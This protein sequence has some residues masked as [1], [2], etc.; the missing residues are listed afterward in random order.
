MNR[1][2]LVV[3]DIPNIRE[4]LEITLRFK[5]YEVVSAADGEEALEIIK[6][7]LPSLV[8]TDILMPRM[9]GFTFIHTLRQDPRTRP[10]PV[11][12]LSATYTTPEDKHF[13]MSL[14]AVRFLEKPIDTEE[15]LLTVAE[16][17]TGET[18]TMP[19]PMD[20]FKFYLE[21]RSRLENKLGHKN[22][23]ITRMERLVQ[24]LPESQKAAFQSLLADAIR[25]RD[26]IQ[27]QLDDIYRR[28]RKND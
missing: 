8:I 17:L 13:A 16:T 23:Q 4:M 7:S 15:F 12:V 10:L 20:D 6:T 3:E 5:G 9:D 21:Y 25:D 24:V 22:S 1:P 18:P 11:I 28:S 2:I 14:G 19:I 26:E 27:Q